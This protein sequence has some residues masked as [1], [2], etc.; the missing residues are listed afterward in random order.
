[1]RQGKTDGGRRG[2]RIFLG[3][4]AGA[5]AV[6]VLITAGLRLLGEYQERQKR[7]AYPYPEEYAALIEKNA[8]DY[9][10]PPEIICA[11]IRTESSF[12]A[13]AVS[14]AGA[15]GL[16]QL[17][18][19]TFTWLQTKT[20]E[21]CEENALTDPAVNVKYGCFL[22]K[23]LYDEFGNWKTVWAAYNAGMNRV[24]TW[25]TDASYADENGL[26]TIPIQETENYVARVERA[27]AV[28][29]ELY[30]TPQNGETPN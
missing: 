11:V 10:I 2:I 27:T 12:R 30:F 4:A 20:G 1:M 23:M 26:H 6:A 24:R 17:M 8:Q 22:L 18:P 21:Q 14:P 13:D 29:R 5:A 28:Y 7:R 19:S 9:G 25:L 16:M 15:V 3:L